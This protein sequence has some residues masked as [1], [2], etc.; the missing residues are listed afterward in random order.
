M[1]V[2]VATGLHNGADPIRRKFVYRRPRVLAAG[3]SLSLS[4]AFLAALDV[5]V[6]GLGFPES[7]RARRPRARG[8][9][10]ALGSNGFWHHGQRVT[11]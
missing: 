9:C 8:E 1:Q 6:C 7:A 5:V 10:R 3:P 11:R 2:I 4:P